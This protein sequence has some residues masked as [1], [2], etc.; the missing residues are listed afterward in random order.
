MFFEIPSLTTDFHQESCHNVADKYVEYDV[1]IIIID[2]VLLQKTAYRH[3]LFNVDFKVRR[4][5]FS[6]DYSRLVEFLET[7]CDSSVNGSVLRT[8][9]KFA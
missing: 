9:A 7:L 5:I 3:V 8:H 2:L 1:V 4:L 6:F